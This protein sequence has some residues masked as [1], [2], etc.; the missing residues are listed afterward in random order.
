MRPTTSCSAPNTSIFK[1][2][3]RDG[4]AEAQLPFAYK[5]TVR[6]VPCMS[7][8]VF[9]LLIPH[10]AECLK[11]KRVHLQHQNTHHGMN[12]YRPATSLCAFHQSTPEIMG[13]M[14]VD[15]IKYIFYETKMKVDGNL[16]SALLMAGMGM[17]TADSSGG[18]S[19]PGLKMNQVHT[20]IYDCIHESSSQH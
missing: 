17:C 19:N 10:T 14:H 20:H 9:S 5:A 6:I 11:H 2:Q 1:A 3:R 12:T 18:S 8:L 16:V 13:V 4:H 7:A 15:V